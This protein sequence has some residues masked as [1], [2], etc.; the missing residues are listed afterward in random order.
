MKQFLL[1]GT[2]L[3]ITFYAVALAL[4]GSI[5]LRDFVPLTPMSVVSRKTH[6]GAGTF[7]IDLPL[8]GSPAIECRTDGGLI[9]DY[10]IVL[11]FSGNV[12]V[13]GDP[14]AQVTLGI[15]MIG[16]GGVSNGGMV[17]ID[18]N[19]VTIP[20]TNVGNAQ[21]INVTLFGVNGVGNVVVPMAVLAGDVNGNGIVNASDV[22]QTKLLI[23]Q[24][25]DL[26]TF[27]CDVSTNGSINATDVTFLKS[28]VGTGLP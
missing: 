6:G 2:I 4:G 8:T 18:G 24:P 20:L 1:R 16:S 10:T 7:D 27:K 22:A 28:K 19:I 14:Q 9:R 21:I 5:L 23:G 17:T 26:T 12:I 3:T 13:T 11:T 15:G 25:I